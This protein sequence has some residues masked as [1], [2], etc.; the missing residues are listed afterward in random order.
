MEYGYMDIEY[1]YETFSGLPVYYGGDMYDSEDSEEDDPLERVPAA[2]VEYYNFDV[3]EGMELMAYN[4]RRPDDGEA[5][6]VDTVDMAPMCHV[7]RALNRMNPVIR[8]ERTPL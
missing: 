5:R 7:S 1:Q 3:P 8:Q 6:S 4:R 2:Y